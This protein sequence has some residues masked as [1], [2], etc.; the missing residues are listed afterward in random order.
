MEE[1]EDPAPAPPSRRPAAAAALPPEAEWADRALIA[2]LLSVIPTARRHGLRAGL[3]VKVAASIVWEILKTSGIDP[4][5][6]ADWADLV[7][8]PAFSAWHD[9]GERLSRSA[10]STVPRLT[11]WP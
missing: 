4:S 11:S 1:R 10:C 2:T 7:S 8:V 9:P 3:R 6:A 5:G